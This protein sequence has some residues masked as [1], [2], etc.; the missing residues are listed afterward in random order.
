MAN[1]NKP[2][3]VLFKDKTAAVLSILPDEA[4][5]QL[6]KALDNY[7]REGQSPLFDGSQVWQHAYALLSA[8]IDRADQKHEQI[9]QMRAESGRKGGIKSGKKRSK[10][11]QTKQMLDNVESVDKSA[12]QGYPLCEANEANEADTD[13]V[14]DTDT[15]TVTANS[16]S[17]RGWYI[18][19]YGEKAYYDAVNSVGSD[20]VQLARYLRAKNNV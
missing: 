20:P 19:Q 8:D 5:G 12:L 11:K 4:A 2:S 10:K 1:M 7:A 13:T 3:Y 17:L 16:F 15:D 14:T 18:E 9:R 6:W